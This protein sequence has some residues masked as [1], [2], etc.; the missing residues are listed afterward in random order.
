[1]VLYGLTTQRV[2]LISRTIIEMKGE[3][4]EKEQNDFQEKR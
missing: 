3:R 2:A 4:N 1:M